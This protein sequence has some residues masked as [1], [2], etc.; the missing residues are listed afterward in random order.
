VRKEVPAEFGA[1][2]GATKASSPADANAGLQN[3]S[4]FFTDPNLKQL[5]ETALANN[6]ELNMRLQEIIVANVEIMARTGEYLPMVGVGVGAGVD[7]PGRYTTEGQSVRNF[8]MPDPKGDFKFGLFASWE[9]DIWKKLRNAAKAAQ[10]RYLA[11]IQGKNFLVTQIIAEIARS[12]YELLALDNQLEVLKRNIKIQQ[13]ALDVVRYEKEA[14][15]V[16]QLA[17]QR[18][19]AE[20]LKNKGRQFYLEQ[21]VIET[22]NKINFLLGRYP[23]R[24]ARNSET[25]NNPVP[26]VI[27]AG[28]PSQLLDNRPDVKQAELALEAAKLDVSVAKKSFYPSLSIDAGVGYESFNMKHLVTTPESLAYNLAGNL[29]APLLNRRAIKAQYYAANAEQL[30]AVYNYERTLLQAFTEVANQ[31]SMIDNLQKSYELESK[32][33]DL[34]TQAIDVSNV[35]FQSARADYMEVLLTR[36]D[37]LTSQ[38]DLIDTKLSQMQSVVNIYQALGGGWR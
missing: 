24:I 4:Q 13:D 25:F 9:I 17:V 37:A 31:V 22:E 10:R 16:T 29:T 15:R 5:I 1:T 36:R 7:K 20:V 19:E 11:S 18:F 33:V 35:L 34:L 23:Q 28:I 8:N 14:A 27:R 38:M 26:T 21:R 12:Y 6:Q 32:Q 30:K 3:W 2:P